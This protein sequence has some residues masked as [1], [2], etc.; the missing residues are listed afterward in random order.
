MLRE[1]AASSSHNELLE[2]YC[3]RRRPAPTAKTVNR[4][5]FEPGSA[6]RASKVAAPGDS[7]AMVVALSKAF[8]VDGVA[9]NVNR[10]RFVAQADVLPI[11]PWLP[12][13]TVGYAED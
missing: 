12:V 9:V 13:P 4:A 1:S 10:A 11:E 2:T 8:V 3:H 6:L 5:T 7:S